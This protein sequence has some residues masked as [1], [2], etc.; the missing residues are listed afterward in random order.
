[1]TKL[2]EIYLTLG[3]D[4]YLVLIHAIHSFLRSYCLHVGQS[5]SNSP[6]H[7]FPSSFSSHDLK[8]KRSATRSII[9][10]VTPASPCFRN[11]DCQTP[12]AEEREKE[13]CIISSSFVAQN[14]LCLHRK[15][16]KKLR[17]RSRVCRTSGKACEV[18]DSLIEY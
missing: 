17:T 8:E 12:T 18:S 4:V 9:P 5:D 14:V 6:S 3:F 11:K 2:E 15:E 16:K 13:Y 10:R 7:S 1:M